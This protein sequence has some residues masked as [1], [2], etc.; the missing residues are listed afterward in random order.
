VFNKKEKLT[1]EELG[2]MLTIN[3][4]ELMGMDDISGSI[5]KGKCAHLVVPD[6][7][8]LE[9]SPE[10]LLETRVLLTLLEG[11]PVYHAEDSPMLALGDDLKT[12]DMWR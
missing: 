12:P 3:G 8:I 2:S 11:K 4:A 5:E 9:C 10:D 1:M 6:R 7:N